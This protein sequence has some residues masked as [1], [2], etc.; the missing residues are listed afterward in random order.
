VAAECILESV[1]HC[2]PL[3]TTLMTVQENLHTYCSYWL[4]SG[5]MNVCFHVQVNFPFAD[6]CKN[7]NILVLDR[8]VEAL[9]VRESMMFFPTSSIVI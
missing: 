6:M 2:L 1:L 5:P 7:N 9:Q 8:K 4:V 3:L